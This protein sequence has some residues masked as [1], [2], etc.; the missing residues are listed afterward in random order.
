[1]EVLTCCQ[2]S[3]IESTR[4]ENHHLQIRTSSLQLIVKILISWALELWCV[5]RTEY[6]TYHNFEGVAVKMFE[7]RIFR[8]VSI[9]SYFAFDHTSLLLI[10]R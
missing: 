8:L 4:L 1:M 9:E 7:I 2:K 10:G 3:N 5:V 6:S